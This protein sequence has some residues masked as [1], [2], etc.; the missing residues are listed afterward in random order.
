M[1]TRLLFFILLLGSASAFAQIQITGKITDAETKEAL[2]STS[3][4]ISPKGESGILGYSISD[5]EG[6]FEI[7]IKSVS[8]S[9]TLKVS[10]LGYAA[11]QKDLA[12][13]TQEIQIEM[14]T[15]AES[16]E[17]VFLRRPPIRQRGDTLIFDPQAFKSNKDRSIQD[18]LSKMP[19]IEIDPSGEILYQGKPINK[20]YVEGLDLMGGQYGMVSNNLNVDKVKSVEILENHQP[21]K[22]LDSIEPS[23]Q[24]AINIKLKNKV[25]V[26]GNV[27]VGAGASPG[28][29]FAKLS[30]MFFIKN[31]QTLVTYQTNNTGTD[32]TR[33]FNRFSFTGF[34]FGRSAN[35]KKD[36]LSI[37][38]SNPPPFSNQRW[39]D[40]ESHAISANTLFKNKKEFE[41]KIN[42]SYINNLTKRNGGSITTYLLPEGNT[43]IEN[44]TKNHLRDE[45]L[46]VSLS[47][48]Q[49]R[50]K[51]FF[52]ENLQFKKEWDR[53]TAFLTENG[54]DQNQKSNQPFSEIKN[55]FE[56]IFPIGK[57]LVTFDS[58]IGYN[59]SPQDLW[60]QPG[61]FSDILN[62]GES[63][64]RVKQEV[65]DKQFFA[66]H[67]LDWTKSFG[68]LSLS[69]Q[70][71]LD[72][73]MRNMDS[74]I[75]L[76]HQIDLDPDF[77]NDMKWQEFSTYLRTGLSYR[78]D[79][80]RIFFR[81]PFDVIHY[82]IED[83]IRQEKQTK[84][85][86]TINPVLW[87][88][89]K[90]QDYWK[91]NLN[92]NFNKNYGPLNEM[93]TGYML[94]N[95]RNLGRHDVPLM[96]TASQSA[97]VGLEYR[98]PITTWF[99]R[100]GYS[101]S[102]AKNDQ[103]FNTITQPDGSV[104]LEAI[105]LTNKRNSNS[106][107]LSV[108]K[109]ISPLKTT[110]KIGSN[111]SRSKSDMLFNSE[112]LKNTSDTWTNSL[113]LS[114][115]FVDW[116]TAEY[117]GSISLSSTENR[118][119]NT[120]RVWSQ[121]HKLG[122]YF[123]FLDDHTLSF[124][125]EWVESKLEGDSWSDFFGDILYRFT[126]PGKRKVDFEFAVV[127]VFDKDMYR[128]LS[129]GNYTIAESYYI[130]RPRQ[131]MLKVRFPL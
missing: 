109:L 37:A 126:L 20:F 43:T 54:V 22:V 69:L 113:N 3:V 108:S 32:V 40:N 18:V 124:S 117:D 125:G 75:L 127:N 87:G 74:Q 90:F 104:V 44:H 6:H 105:D 28:L 41:F 46:Q 39:L 23:D 35:S 10:S 118:L 111:Y 68:K 112:L 2:G 94:T 60:V 119:Q 115:D 79:D 73:T 42:A 27:E 131:F 51:K 16:L 128:D 36:W 99:A 102:G 77:Q 15:A 114:G 130:L 5:N 84:N 17:E 72:F 33:D 38:S 80:L 107:N 93:Y 29:W 7:K 57:Q 92:L 24:A 31:F 62:P 86:F 123:Y 67:S 8:D 100:L 89:Y 96:E 85:P 76:D 101:Y 58:N 120:R 116:M 97:S 4:V 106:V 71:G 121:N 11:F 78:S 25:T 65:F 30:P 52:K 55:D 13:Q 66:N 1:K 59:E 129:V 45:S 26:S 110:F 88:E 83:R 21:L 9:L 12:P 61:V 56:I 95:Y 81:L 91:T 82:Q 50:A 122:L 47:V 53:H 48:E 64:D 103:I 63:V 70:P 14:E 98:N 19:G 49:N 34:R